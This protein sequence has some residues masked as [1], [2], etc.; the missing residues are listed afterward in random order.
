MTG[1]GK[2][3]AVVTYISGAAATWSLADINEGLMAAGLVLGAV[4]AV[5]RIL[6]GIKHWNKPPSKE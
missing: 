1:T 2:D 5:M 4:L 3:A 6:Q